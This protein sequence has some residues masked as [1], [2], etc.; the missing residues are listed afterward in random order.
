MSRFLNILP[1]WPTAR[2]TEALVTDRAGKAEP[3]EAFQTGLSPD[4]LPRWVRKSASLTRSG[5]STAAACAW[6]A[7]SCVAHG[8]AITPAMISL[9]EGVPRTVMETQH[10]NKIVSFTMSGNRPRPFFSPACHLGPD[11]RF[12]Q[13]ISPPLRAARQN[14]APSPTCG[15]LE[16]TDVCQLSSLCRWGS[17]E[18]AAQRA[19][20]SQSG[21]V[22][23]AR[24]LWLCAGSNAGRSP[25]LVP[26]YK[27]DLFVPTLVSFP[28][29]PTQNPSVVA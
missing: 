6:P 20:Q 8:T 21:G 23:I 14:P 25:F 1:V 12:G 10:L 17:R 27:W 18:W 26:G 16:S 28:P 9:A 4:G 7:V 5:A 11:A 29:A 15:F 22:G 24:R 3:P 19:R 2:K 13:D